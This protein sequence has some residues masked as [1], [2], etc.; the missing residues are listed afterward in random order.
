VECNGLM[1]YDR[2]VVKPN[3]SRIAAVNRG[4]FSRVPPPPVTKVVVPTSEE[5]GRDWKYLTVTPP[6]DWFKPDFD[7][8]TWSVGP[9][10]FGTKGTPGVVVRT[11]WNTPDIWIRSEFTLSS[12]RFTSLHFR[13]HHDDDAEVYVNGISA[14]TMDGYS[15]EYEEIPVAPVGLKALKPGRNVIAVHCK[16]IQGGQYIDVG[17]V[18]LIPAKKKK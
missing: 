5:Q 3:L 16:Q 11:E 10:G 8:G 13:M 7:D 18:D 14:G 17:L 15:R 9:A 1:T 2:A 12:I 6:A 4:D